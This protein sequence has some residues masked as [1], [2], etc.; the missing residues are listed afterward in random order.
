MIKKIIISN[1][2]ILVAFGFTVFAQ[3]KTTIN[4]QYAKRKLIGRHFLSLQWI[5]WN[6]LGRAY[7]RQRKGVLYL[8]GTQKGRKN[9]DYLKIDGIITEVNRYNFKFRGKIITHVSY[10]NEGEPCVREGDMTFLI[11]GKR[12]YWRL[13]EMNNPCEKIVDYIDIYFR[14]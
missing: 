10:N 11:K 7:V 12:K 9:D 6:Y 14:K 2:L 4:S 5:S 13:Q 1:L 3:P 8:K